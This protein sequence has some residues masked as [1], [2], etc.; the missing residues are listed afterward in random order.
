LAQAKTQLELSWGRA[1]RSCSEAK[2]GDL[3]FQ[4]NDRRPE[5][6]VH[7]TCIPPK[8][9]PTFPSRSHHFPPQITLLQHPHGGAAGASRGWVTAP[10]GD[11]LSDDHVI[12]PQ[13]TLFPCPV[14]TSRARVQKREEWSN[15]GRRTCLGQVKVHPGE[16]EEREVEFGRL[17]RRF[18][19]QNSRTA[20]EICVLKAEGD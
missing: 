3:P 9:T 8:R 14:A 16:V 2:P 15:R 1:D 7:K 17:H 20:G 6:N 19:R 13:T 10:A 11:G 4:A 5:G 12:I 18:L